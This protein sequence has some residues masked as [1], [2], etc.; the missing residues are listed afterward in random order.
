LIFVGIGGVIRGA[1][2]D[3]TGENIADWLAKLDDSRQ[4]AW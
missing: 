2:I 1:V 3:L 4:V